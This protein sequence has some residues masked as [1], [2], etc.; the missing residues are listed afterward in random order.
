VIVL[1]A[2]AI[3]ELLL[4]TTR[5]RVVA[6]RI[7]DPTLGLHAPHLVD[8]EVAQALRRYVRGGEID[9]AAGAL[10]L[11]DLRSLDVER[12]PHEPLLAR[13]WDLRE[14]L[15]AYDAVYVALAEALDSKVLTC[16]SRLG[17]AP[18]M[19]GR[20]DVVSEA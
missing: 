5:G 16:D 8:V 20:V 14:N 13:V 18:G 2:S 7:G 9:E 15:T 11:E 3:L 17:R 12:H 4:G 1:D 10:A 19:R 6:E